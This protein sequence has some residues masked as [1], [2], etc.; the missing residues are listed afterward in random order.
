MG[1]IKKGLS[2]IHEDAKKERLRVVYIGRRDRLHKDLVTLIETIEEETRMYGGF[3]LCIAIDY[4]GEDE[5]QRAER[6]KDESNSTKE[7]KEYLDTS[8]QNIPYLDLVIRTGGER[9]TSG[10]MPLQSSYAEW[11]F[12]EKMFPDFT[13]EVFQ[14]ALDEFSLRMRRFGK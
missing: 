14:K 4:G 6:R 5:I 13:V 2:K 12:E 9:R 7:I 3:T 8:L 1:L 10:F 11:V